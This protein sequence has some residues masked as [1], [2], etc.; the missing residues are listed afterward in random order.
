MPTH[1]TFIATYI[2]ASGRNGTLYIGMTANLFA[3]V[4]KH[5]NGTFPGFTDDHDCTRLV[6]FQRYVWVT[7]AIKREKQLKKWMR[8]WKLTLIET[9]NP[10]W[11][12]LAA[13]WCPKHDPNWLPPTDP[14]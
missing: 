2:L 10:D 4:W 11:H 6:W 3:R 12:D 5:R 7:G 8:P 13:D 14:D 1:R 9:N